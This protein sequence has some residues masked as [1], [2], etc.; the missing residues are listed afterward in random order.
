[1]IVRDGAEIVA[2]VP[3]GIIKRDVGPVFVSPLGASVG[4]PLILRPLLAETSAII[5]ALQSYARVRAARR[6]GV[7]VT[8]GGGGVATTIS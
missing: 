6:R 1:M 4:G 5:E 7:V 3:G 2:V 8:H